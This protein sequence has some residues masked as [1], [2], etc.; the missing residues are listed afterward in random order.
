MFHFNALTGE[1]VLEHGIRDEVLHGLDV[2]DGAMVE[3]F[4]MPDDSKTIILLDEFLQARTFTLSIYL[5]AN[6]WSS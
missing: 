6:E 5:H 2:I 1:T 3:A 4:M